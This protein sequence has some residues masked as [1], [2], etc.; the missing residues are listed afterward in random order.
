MAPGRGSAPAARTGLDFWKTLGVTVLFIT[1]VVVLFVV[2]QVIGLWDWL[3]PL[4]RHL[5]STPVL[6]PH[7]E[8]YRLGREDWR[9][10]QDEQARLASWE[11]ELKAQADR[12]AEQESALKR[13]QDEL[14]QA[15]ARVAAWEAELASRQAAVERL[16]DEQ[17]SLE[18]VRE[19][20]EAMRPQEAA[21]IM[22]DMSDDEVA[23]LLEDMDPRTASAILTALP[24]D[25]AVIV[26]RTLGL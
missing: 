10:L 5:A 19:L 25:K 22:A 20:Y 13:A 14:E 6:A 1:S 26:S 3:N 12:L 21:R 15:W 8:M 18:R 17:R 16:E 23:R 11:T 24:V 9:V 4:T 2:L 7:V